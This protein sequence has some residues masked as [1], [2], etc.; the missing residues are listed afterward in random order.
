[1][2]V[3]DSVANALGFSAPAAEHQTGNVKLLRREY[4]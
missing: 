3:A 1:M 2:T 4:R